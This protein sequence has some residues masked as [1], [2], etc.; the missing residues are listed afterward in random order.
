M[1]YFLNAA[2][3]KLT[4]LQFLSILNKL[5]V[6]LEDYMS[7]R[8]TGPATQ[9]P[10]SQIQ[11]ETSSKKQEEPQIQITQPDVV[12]SPTNDQVL[13][14]PPPPPRPQDQRPTPSPPSHIAPSPSPTSK[15]LSP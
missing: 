8:E 7:T 9:Q 1:L 12:P 10:Q 15:S 4:S 14:P 2:V 6:L 3:A 11:P 5:D 13:M